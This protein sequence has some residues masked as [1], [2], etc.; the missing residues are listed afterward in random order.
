M[1]WIQLP[2]EHVKTNQ[3]TPLRVPKLDGDLAT[4]YKPMRCPACDF[5]STSR[6]GFGAHVSEHDDSE[7]LTFQT[8]QPEIVEAT[9]VSVLMIL[10][11]RLGNVGRDDPIGKVLKQN[12]SYQSGKLWDAVWRAFHHEGATHIKI[13]HKQYEWVHSVLERKLPLSKEQKD[14]G[15]EADT[16]ATHVFNLS[17]HQVVQALTMESDRLVESTDTED[18][19]PRPV[20]LTAAEESR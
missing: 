2:I 20:P 7:A 6:E 13:H 3:G 10:L 9:T 4:V 18:A 14:D 5:S 19:R 8:P 16:V 11:M 15:V 17:W 12:D 1:S